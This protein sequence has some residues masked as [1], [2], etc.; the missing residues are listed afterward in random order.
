M[1]LREGREAQQGSLLSQL[2]IQAGIDLGL[3]KHCK[4][5]ESSRQVLWQMVRETS[6][7]TRRDLGSGECLELGSGLCGMA[8]SSTW[9]CRSG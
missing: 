8:T 3:R 1:L 7:V 5:F 4:K 6:A 2:P 9:P